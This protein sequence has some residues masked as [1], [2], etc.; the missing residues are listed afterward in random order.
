MHSY[1]YECSTYMN[2]LIWV[3]DSILCVHICI[4]ICIHT[5]INAVHM[6]MHI[7]VCI[8]ICI[9]T[10]MNAVHIWMHSH[11]RVRLNTLHSYM[12]SY[13]PSYMHSYMYCLYCSL[14]PI[15]ECSTYIHIH[16][17]IYDS[18]A[19]YMNAV[20]IYIYAF[21]YVLHSCMGVRLNKYVLCI[22][23]CTLHSYTVHACIVEYIHKCMYYIHTC[24]G[25]LQ[26][27]GSIKL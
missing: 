6:W 23:I 22:H 3:W 27:V 5:Y 16:A 19:T 2:A 17:F 26:L 10:Y 7:H 25:W 13:M 21:I 24:M 12:P 8:H 18:I 15:Y 9:H 11:T 14:T 1:I 4:H 20:H